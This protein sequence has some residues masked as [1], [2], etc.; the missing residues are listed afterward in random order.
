M[1]FRRFIIIAAL[2][3]VTYS[4]IMQWKHDYHDVE[5]NRAREKDTAAVEFPSAQNISS[6][7]Q[8]SEN[9][10]S[11]AQSQIDSD[12]PRVEVEEEIKL[13]E[14]PVK[15]FS[16]IKVR[17]DV[18]EYTINPVGGDIYGVLLLKYKNSL[19]T[20]D[21]P[22]SLLENNSNR[23]YIAQSGLIGPDGPDANKSG[24]PYYQTEKNT[25]DMGNNDTLEVVLSTQQN[26]VEVRKIFTFYKGNYQVNVKYKIENNSNKEWKAN[27]FGQIKRDNSDVPG[28]VKMTMGLKPFLGGAYWTEEKP[29][30][31][32]KF[33]DFKKEAVRAKVTGGW[34]AIVQHYFVSAWIPDP[35][36]THS[37]TTRINKDNEN[38][39]GFT[40]PAIR[41]QAGETTEISSNFY[42]GPKIIEDLKAVAPGFDLTLDLGWLWMISKLLIWGLDHINALVNNL[43]VSIIIL[44]VIVKIIFFYP[45]AASFRSMANMRRIQPEM[46]RLKELYGDDRQKMSQGMIELYKKEKVNPLGGCLPILLQMPVFIALY[47]ALMESVQLR[48][49]S[50]MFWIDDLSVMDPY[51]VLPLIMGATMFIQQM[52]NPAPPD[53]MQAKVMKMM[54]IMFTFFFL[55]FPAGLVLYWVVNN[56]LSIIQQYV[57]TKKIEAGAK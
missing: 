26:G 22:F 36:Q 19:E 56:T 31:K 49:S 51:F 9:S 41:L 14:E 17:T 23:V 30:N 5:K 39:I 34:A 32:L 4:L 13:K 40:S 54:P 28:E 15:N 1:D 52:L 48:H 12:I 33:E 46:Q 20:P 38:I 27:L 3:I 35:E 55:W 7:G 47:W 21:I 42:A 44:T 37:Y 16:A 18:V 57:I 8:S 6:N 53:P 29:Y 43:G 10:S 11:A 25:Y 45:S 24:R 2:A 50:F